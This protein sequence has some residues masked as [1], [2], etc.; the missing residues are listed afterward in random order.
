M[1]NHVYKPRRENGG[2]GGF[3]LNIFTK[4]I[5]YLFMEEEN[6][7]QRGREIGRKEPRGRKSL[8]RKKR[9]EACKKT[10]QMV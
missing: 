3:L 1:A 5:P 10:K 2:V 8:R 6:K 9:T 7:R 4:V